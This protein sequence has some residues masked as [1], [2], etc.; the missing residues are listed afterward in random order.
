[1]SLTL[2]EAAYR[3]NDILQIG[4]IEKLVYDDPILQ[5]L[6]FKD[7][8][9]NGLTYNVEKTMSSANWYGVGETWV[10]STSTVDQHTAVTHILGGDAD[11]DNF[12]QATRS[13][14]QDLMTEQMTA[15]IKAIKKSYMEMFWYGYYLAGAGGDSKGFDGLHYL[16]RSYTTNPYVNSFAVNDSSNGT[17]AP[18]STVELEEAVDAIKN[19]KPE[20]IVMTKQCRRNLNVYLNGVGGITKEVHEGKTVQTMFDV[21]I[22]VSDY[23]SNDEAC[24]SVY[25]YGGD[26]GHDYA[27]GTALA[28]DDDSTTVFVLRF[29]DEAV[30]GIQSMPIT[31]DPIGKLETKDAT[32]VRIKWYP[33]LMLQS[34]ITASK[35]SG[36]SNAAWTVS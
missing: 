29:G 21:P 8:V 30:C 33:G 13:N 35:Y 9:G 7:I 22:A 20:L 32:R 27:D 12:L 6:P 28:N 26:Y 2:T 4:I 16:I 1:M 11:V 18:A 17:A 25:F 36:I 23:L 10:E 3:S 31:T 24:D 34:I 19:G 5:R 15:K 14:L